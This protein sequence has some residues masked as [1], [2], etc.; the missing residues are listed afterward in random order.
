MAVPLTIAGNTFLFPERG[1]DPDW[2]GDTTDWA[3][4]V[5]GA[6]NTLLGSG[7]ILNVTA[8]ISNNIAVATNVNGLIFNPGTIRAANITYAIYRTSTANPSGFSET[9]TIYL[10]Y[11]NNASAANKWLLSQNS[12]G[13]SGVALSVL[14]SGQVQ[15][16]STDINST[17]YTGVIKFSAKALTQI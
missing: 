5:T 6:L 16:V 3:T 12:V 7:D 14:D 15:Y 10:T 8:S 1:E 9:G 13:N 4:A 11:D 17:G 2:S